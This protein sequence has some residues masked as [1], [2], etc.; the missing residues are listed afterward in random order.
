VRQLNHALSRNRHFCTI[1]NKRRWRYCWRH[2]LI[3]WLPLFDDPSPAAAMAN[4]LGYYTGAKFAMT[5][6]RV[7]FD[8]T[9]ADLL[10]SMP[11]T[12]A[13]LYAIMGE[14]SGLQPSVNTPSGAPLSAMVATLDLNA[15]LVAKESLLSLMTEVGCLVCWA[16]RLL[17]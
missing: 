6:V 14:G 2:C 15:D 3:A 12:E 17:C 1:R 10:L 4:D 5:G 13:D 8:V 11:W 9:M 16:A 7:S